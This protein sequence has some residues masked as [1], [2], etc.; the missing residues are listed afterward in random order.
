MNRQSLLLILKE[1]SLSIGNSSIKRNIIFKKRRY[2]SDCIQDELKYTMKTRY[3]FA[4]E[5]DVKSLV[6][7]LKCVSLRTNCYASSN[8]EFSYSD[9]QEW[10]ADLNHFLFSSWLYS[11]NECLLNFKSI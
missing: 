10:L 7:E 4:W 2:L 8:I 11:E 6:L 1:N 9:Q 3:C 5:S